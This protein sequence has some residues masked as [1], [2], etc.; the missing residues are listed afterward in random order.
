MTP[1]VFVTAILISFPARAFAGSG[2]EP[3]A[4]EQIR[5]Q[6]MDTNGDRKISRA[7]WRGTD[8]SFR[9][10][11]W[12]GDRVLSGNEVRVGA[13]RTW[14]EED[15]FD[16][17]RR[18][19]FRNWTERGFANL[20]R[21]RD[22][23]IVRSEWFYDREGFIRTDRNR[24]GAL[25][26]EE[27][28]G[29]EIDT[30]REDRFEYL[31]ANNDGRIE[32]SEW[33]ASRDAFAWLDRNNDGILSRTEV[34]GE[35]V[36]QSDLFTSLDVNNDNRITTNEW[37]WSRRSFAR[38]DQNGDGQLTRSELTNAELDAVG[39]GA[40]GTSGRAIVIDTARGW[41]DTGID[42][43]SGDRISIEASGTATLSDNPADIADAAGSRTGR[44]ADAAPLSNA[45]AG[46][47][48][49]R[50]DNAAPML[51]GNRRAFTA[52]DSGRLYLSVND[53]HFADN[54]GEYR[55]T[56]SASR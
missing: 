3:Q 55:V 33:H 45:P 36:E 8:Q 9:R 11:D 43:R 19:E 27:F 4:E 30:D 18:P 29:F 6:A 42:V 12:N 49:A 48:I 7:E 22:G 41:V 17:A 56:I 23:R 24:D 13:N 44:R 2:L 15:D 37:Q 1:R 31:D 53:D 38:Q 54:R 26:R 32:R 47:L 34:V 40:V 16:Q 10:H 21:N 50:I 52:T 25:T 5:F 20:D 14:G 39:G 46:A 51:V 35:D 28:L